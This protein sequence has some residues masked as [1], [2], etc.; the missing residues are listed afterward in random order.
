MTVIDVAPERR[1]LKWHEANPA[2]WARERAEL[3]ATGW[4][5]RITRTRKGMGLLVNLPVLDIGVVRLQVRFRQSYP[6]VPPDVYDADGVLHGSRHVQARTRELCL[7]HYEDWN[8][9]TTVAELL[10]SQV[11]RLVEANRG[12]D[13][14]LPRAGL[15]VPAPEPVVAAVTNHKMSLVVNDWDI[16]AGVDSGVLVTRFRI[17]HR[18]LSGGIVESLHAPGLTLTCDLDEEQLSYFSVP[19]LGRWLRDQQYRAGESPS[20]TWRRIAGRLQPL[21]VEAEGG[22]ARIMPPEDVEV[23]GL[24]VPDEVSYRS[25]GESWIFL[26]RVKAASGRR[27]IVR[28][29]TQYFSR[30]LLTERTPLSATLAD[31][32]VVVVGLG[33]IGMPLAQDL[34]QSGVGRM[35]LIDRD[36]VD[37]RTGSRQ[38][39]ALFNTGRPKAALAVEVVSALAPYCEVDGISGSLE[40]LWDHGDD[41]EHAAL[42]RRVRTRLAQADLVV[43]ATAS[44]PITRLLSEVQRSAGQPLLVAS[45]TAGGWGGVVT[46]LTQDTGCWACVEHAR[47]DGLLPIPPADPDGWVTPARCSETTY[48]GPRFA[49]QQIALHGSAL[50]ISHLTDQP[51]A[52]G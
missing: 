38:A 31:K 6:W 22:L 48:T 14:T 39:G 28:L 33:A 29:G 19:V 15:E 35:M 16:P 41:P 43:D 18:R 23:I 40:A 49:S 13:T 42:L 21:T 50:A 36:V 3:D 17:D 24:L 46:L 2:R 34:A 47:L 5:Y 44:L 32:D 30:A 12:G 25:A 37:P 26:A 52:G 4:A 10:S 45:G 51:M 7:V 20:A 11:P 9:N 1:E 8:S 27:R